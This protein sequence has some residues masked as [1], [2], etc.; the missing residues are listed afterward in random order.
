LTDDE[1]VR[2]QKELESILHYVEKLQQA[3][4]DDLTPTYQVTGLHTVMRT[5]DIIDYGTSKASLL[6][7]APDQEAG[8]FKVKRM[9]G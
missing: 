8:H 7:N 5:D 9:V 6:Q 4:T 3:D 1:V 2:Y